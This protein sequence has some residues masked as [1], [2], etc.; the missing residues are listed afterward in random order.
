MIARTF[1]PVTAC[2]L[3]IATA[4]AR[5]PSDEPVPKVTAYDAKGNAF[6]LDERLKGHYSVVVFGCLT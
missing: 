4:D 5:V 6:R 2:L 1:L 3:S